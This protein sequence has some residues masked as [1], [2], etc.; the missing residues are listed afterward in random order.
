MY[1][2]EAMTPQKS[3]PAKIKARVPPNKQASRPQSRR[4]NLQGSHRRRPRSRP[5]G[6]QQIPGPDQS[7]A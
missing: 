4:T 2:S 1:G 5:A 3:K 6:P 7:M